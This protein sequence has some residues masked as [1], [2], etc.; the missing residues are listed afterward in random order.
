MALN[1]GDFSSDVLASDPYGIPCMV[2]IFHYPCSLLNYMDH[3]EMGSGPNPIVY[4]ED[5][6]LLALS[7]INSAIE[8]GGYF[9]QRHS[10][11]LSL[12][13]DELFWNL[14][15]LGL[16]TSSLILPIVCSIVLN[17]YRYLQSELKLQIEAFF[18]FLVLRLAES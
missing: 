13:Q 18:S 17:L 15:H 11:L 6:P 10:K 8:L 16:S 2:E 12:I 9:I 5:V 4:D 7:L 1:N 14:M 3:E